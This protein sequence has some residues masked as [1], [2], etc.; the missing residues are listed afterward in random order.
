MRGHKAKQLRREAERVGG[1]PLRQEER[2]YQ[3]EERPQFMLVPV[4][5][6]DGSIKEQRVEIVKLIFRA[7]GVRGY[8]QFIKRRYKKDAP[9]RRAW[10][11]REWL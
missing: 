10:N 4:P 8:Y 5:Q 9:Y 2:T 3:I 11:R 7:V 1:R 6:D